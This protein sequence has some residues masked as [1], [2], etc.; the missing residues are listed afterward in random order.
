M[1]YFICLFH[2]CFHEKIQK[3]VSL[4]FWMSLSSSNLTN[5]LKQWILLT[6][7]KIQIVYF[8]CMKQIFNCVYQQDK[9]KA[10]VKSG[11]FTRLPQNLLS[12]PSP[13]S[14]IV[15][16]AQSYF[17]LH[18]GWS[19]AW[20]HFRGNIDDPCGVIA[21]FCGVIADSCGVVAIPEV[22]GG[23]RCSNANLCTT[24]YTS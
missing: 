11:M 21:N 2:S 12:Q 13:L 7:L 22:I 19:L 9:C 10:F 6:F 20:D 3:N 24:H 14:K 17:S 5:T 18:S 15:F 1:Y 23:C 4:N 8:I 16:Q